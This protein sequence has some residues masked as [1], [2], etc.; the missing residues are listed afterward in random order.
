MVFRKL[1]GGNAVAGWREE[2]EGGGGMTQVA[3]TLTQAIHVLSPWWLILGVMELTFWM[4]VA[5]QDGGE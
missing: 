1:A 3:S 4:M 2:A 5:P